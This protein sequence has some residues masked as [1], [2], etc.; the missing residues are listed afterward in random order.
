M[1]AFVSSYH[2]IHDESTWYKYKLL[3]G[4]DLRKDELQPIL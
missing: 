1:Q 4:N 2:I 3:F